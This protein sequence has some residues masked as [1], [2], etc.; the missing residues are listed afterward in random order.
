MP[1]PH[2]DMRHVMDISLAKVGV[3]AYAS[4]EWFGKRSHSGEVYAEEV[5][6]LVGKGDKQIAACA[7][8]TSSNTS[9]QKGLFG[10][11]AELFSWFYIGCCVHAIDLLSEDITKI[12][13]I[14]SGISDCKFIVLFV[15]RYSMLHETFVDSQAA[16]RKHDPTAS[17]LGLKN[18]PDTRFAY[19]F[20]MIFSVF[21]I[22]PF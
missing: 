11:L 13:E 9:M 1:S 19:A 12:P 21:V 18:F 5:K 17:M 6:R 16:R 7:D 2:R 22:G 8:N 3:A 15:I 14:A 10:K 4:A 20:F